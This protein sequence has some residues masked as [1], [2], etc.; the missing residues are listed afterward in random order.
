MG[1]LGRISG[2]NVE[3]KVGKYS[4]VFGEVLLGLHREFERQDSEIK[5][6][7]EKTGKLEEKLNEMK[8]A[9]GLKDT[10]N[11]WIFCI[12]SYVFALGIGVIVWIIK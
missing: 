2:K 9:D 7:K 4:E 6:N 5:Q 8:K 1:F 3:E 12:L 10:K 11:L